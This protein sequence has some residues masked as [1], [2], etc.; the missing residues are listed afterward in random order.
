VGTTESASRGA[1]LVRTMVDALQFDTVDRSDL[2]DTVTVLVGHDTDLDAIATAMNVAWEF[3]APYST[4]KNSLDWYSTP[5]G[6]AI[7]ITHEQESSNREGGVVTLSYFYPV[8]N[9]KANDGTIQTWDLI[10]LQLR[11][12][13]GDSGIVMNENA[14]IL[15]WRQFQQHINTTLQQYTGA[16]DCYNS[17]TK[18]IAAN[19]SADGGDRGDRNPPTMPSTQPPYP[20]DI[21]PQDLGN[22]SNNSTSSIDAISWSSFGSG[23]GAAVA[24]VIV[25]LF[26]SWFCR[27]RRQQRLRSQ[28]SET[29]SALRL[30]EYDVVGGRRRK[31]DLV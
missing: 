17:A 19:I 27:C 31:V 12:S 11:N 25:L 1:V 20:T 15:T 18:Y 8:F 9:L 16:M 6:S 5:P 3:R 23:F 2:G 7:F 28:Y 29:S 10:P 21:P 4:D 13:S 30:Q 14:T 22:A 24:V 26:A